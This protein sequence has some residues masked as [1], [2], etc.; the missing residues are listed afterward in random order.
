[1]EKSGG[2]SRT[3]TC[4]PLIKRQFPGHSTTLAF[5]PLQTAKPQDDLKP[6]IVAGLNAVVD[7]R[8]GALSDH[9]LGGTLSVLAQCETRSSG[10][11]FLLLKTTTHT[12]L[13]ATQSTGLRGLSLCHCVVNIG[14]LSS[15]AP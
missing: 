14:A 13:S 8:C 7:R 2:C 9:C 15:G 5:L 12:L 1:M 6:S 10:V 11:H 4:D 3:R